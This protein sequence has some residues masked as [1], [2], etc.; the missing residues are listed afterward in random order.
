MSR[1]LILACT[2][3]IATPVHAYPTM[4]GGACDTPAGCL[5]PLPE[6]ANDSNIGF[7]WTIPD[8]GVT[9]KWTFAI[10]QPGAT[11]FVPGGN[12]VE[13][14]ESVKTPTGTNDIY[15]SGDTFPYRFERVY[16]QGSNITTYFVH[17][18]KGKPDTCDTAA[19]GEI[20]FLHYQVWNN[21]Q[22]YSWSGTQGPFTMRISVLAVPEP[23]S[24]AMMI[25]GF[26]L[27]GAWMRRV[28]RGVCPQA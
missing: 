3:L 1:G 12:Q 20:C 16:E 9:Y 4:F 10:D 13:F 17:A 6:D 22:P 11:V 5:I 14:F 25:A 2:A 27:F 15:A 23:A 7:D 19:V 24:W 18:P 8:D 21:G 28:R 26:G